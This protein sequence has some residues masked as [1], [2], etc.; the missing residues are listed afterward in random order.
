MVSLIAASHPALGERFLYCDGKVSLLFTE[1]ETNT[2]RIFGI[3]NKSPYVKDGIHKHIVNGEPSAV[4]PQRVGTKASAHYLLEIE[5]GG[6]KEIRLRLCDGPLPRL[7]KPMPRP[8]GSVRT[9][10]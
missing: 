7:A 5:A 9:P 8:A 4:N 1:N 10:V 2:E 6:S 3:P